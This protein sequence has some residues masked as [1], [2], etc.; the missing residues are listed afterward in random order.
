M[1]QRAADAMHYALPRLLGPRVQC[2]MCAIRRPKFRP[3]MPHTVRCAP[4]TATSTASHHPAYGVR[5]AASRLILLSW[6]RRPLRGSPAA[7]GSWGTTE[8]ASSCINPDPRTVDTNN[9]R[10]NLGPSPPMSCS[11]RSDS[12]P[13][14]GSSRRARELAVGVSLREPSRVWRL[15][16]VRSPSQRIILRHCHSGPPAL[17]PR[18]IIVCCCHLD[19]IHG[20]VSTQVSDSCMCYTPELSTSRLQTPAPWIKPWPAFAGPLLSCRALRKS[21][22][23]NVIIQTRGHRGPHRPMF[24]CSYGQDGATVAVASWDYYWEWTPNSDPIATQHR[25]SLDRRPSVT[26]PL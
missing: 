5:R 19:C 8:W 14:L 16:R 4:H 20:L 2:T 26:A 17:R 25:T 3:C 15:D 9:Q 12:A 13:Q 24:L 23:R 11:S 10:R 18:R 7:R 1:Q 22:A 21:L 6:T